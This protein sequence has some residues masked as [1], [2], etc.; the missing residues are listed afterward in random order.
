MACRITSGGKV[1]SGVILDLS[2][3]GVFVQTSAKP[4]PGEGFAL[5]ISVPGQRAP[6]RLEAQVARVQ[7]VPP[8]LL[9]VAHGGIGLRIT[10]APEGYFAFLAAVLPGDGA[11]AQ[12]TTAPTSSAREAPGAVALA[13]RA[14][15]V[16]VTQT[17]GARSRTLRVRA[18]SAEAAAARALEETG[19][20][21]KV[22]ECIDDEAAPAG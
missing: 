20:G 21:W 14:F 7:V 5:E 10:N 6:L 4:R 8:S 11:E 12:P 19:E 3:T 16:R 15:R 1:F 17:G 9:N 13:S 18:P 2:A 22:L